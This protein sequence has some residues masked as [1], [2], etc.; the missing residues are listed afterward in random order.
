MAA[1]RSNRLGRSAPH[2]P[3]QQIENN[4]DVRTAA[5]PGGIVIATPILMAL[6]ERFFGLTQRLR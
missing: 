3:W 2:P 1:A 6:A 4:L 5:A